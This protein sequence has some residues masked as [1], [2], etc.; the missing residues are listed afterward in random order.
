MRHERREFKFHGARQLIS[1]RGWLGRFDENTLVGMHP[2]NKDLV[3]MSGEVAAAATKDCSGFNPEIE[4]PAKR[5]HAL[6]QKLQW[7]DT[8]Q[9]FGHGHSH[10]V[11]KTYEVKCSSVAPDVLQVRKLAALP[12]PHAKRAGQ[13]IH[14]VAIAAEEHPLAANIRGSI[15]RECQQRFTLSAFHPARYKHAR[16]FVDER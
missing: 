5:R 6:A 9:P 4:L 14:C 13:S 1:Y 7:P 10:G 16:A 15:L 11:Q 2:P 12:F 3:G 8:G